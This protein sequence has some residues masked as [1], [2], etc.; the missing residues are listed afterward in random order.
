VEEAG[1]GF[2]RKMRDW[3]NV[4]ASHGV[5]RGR[6]RPQSMAAPRTGSGEE[7]EEVLIFSEDARCDDSHPPRKKR[8]LSVG[9]MDLET[10]HTMEFNGTLSSPIDHWDSLSS[11]FTSDEETDS[12]N[13]GSD[14]LGTNT[15]NP[16][17]SPMSWSYSSDSPSFSLMHSFHENHRNTPSAQAVTRSEKALAALALAMANGAGLNDYQPVLNASSGSSLPNDYQA[18]E[19]WE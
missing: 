16:S 17:S 1:E 9:L 18:G 13:V 5:R 11:D 10:S 19:L 15:T 12:V 2:V 6:K 14:N 3:E 8:A 4:R 7:E